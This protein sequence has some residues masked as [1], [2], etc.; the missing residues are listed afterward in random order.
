[1]SRTNVVTYQLRPES[2]DEHVKLIEAVFEQLHRERPTDMDYRVLVL[3]DGVSFVHISTHDAG[4]GPN[5]L[6]KL[7]AFQRFNEGI[8]DRVATPPNPSAARVVGAY[9]PS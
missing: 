9:Q 3:D 5:P 6:T 4:D 7:E 2:Y 8:A 1:M